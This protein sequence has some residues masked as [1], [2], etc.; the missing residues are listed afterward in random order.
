MEREVELGDRLAGAV[1][2]MEGEAAELAARRP[3]PDA[4]LYHIEEGLRVR[5]RDLDAFLEEAYYR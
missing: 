2:T 1:A 4:H 3:H 5:A